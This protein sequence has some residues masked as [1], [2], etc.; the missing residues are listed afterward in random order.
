MHRQNLPPVFGFVLAC[1]FTQGALAQEAGEEPPE[2]VT[3][4]A[5]NKAELAADR[6]AARSYVLTTAQLKGLTDAALETKSDRSLLTSSRQFRCRDEA[7][8]GS[9]TELLT[10]AGA[11]R[12]IAKSPQSAKLLARHG[13]TA[14]DVALWGYL[15]IPLLFVASP[16]MSAMAPE[17]AA[18]AKARLS[19]QQSAFAK[20]NVAGLKAWLETD[21]SKPRP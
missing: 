11:G 5:C 14:R 20:Q 7:G 12:W 2:E 13:L 16:E 6:A 8:D 17:A 19:A 21:T 9:R 10:T 18:D 4:P 1:A 15:A 3:L